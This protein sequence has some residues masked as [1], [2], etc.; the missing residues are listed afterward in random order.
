MQILRPSTPFLA[1][2]LD[3]PL[4]SSRVSAFASA[5]GVTDQRY[6]YI[7]VST[8]HRDRYYTGTDV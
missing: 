7:L 4:E 3:I 1:I 8:I 2:V 5:A 6:V